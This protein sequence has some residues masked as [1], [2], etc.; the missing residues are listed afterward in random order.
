MS[1]INQRT[2]IAF[3]TGFCLMAYELAAARLLAPTVG[4]STY[5]WTSVIGVIIA[6]L[7]FGF[8][9]GGKIADAR[10]K[11]TDLAWLLLFIAAAILWTLCFNQAILSWVEGFAVDLR[12]QAVVVA[13]ILFAPASFLFGLISPYLAKLQVQ[14]LTQTGQA[15]ATL[16]ASNSLG[17]ITGTFATGFVLFSYTG[18]RQTLAI[19][20]VLILMMSWIITPRDGLM[21]RL[22]VSIGLVLAVITCLIMPPP[23]VTV[24]TATASYKIVDSQS[25]SGR[26]IRN[27]KT[28]PGGSQSGIYLDG[29]KQLPFWYTNEM[30]RLAIKFQPKSVLILG[31]GALT[32]PEYLAKQLPATTI[33][34]VELDP[35]LEKIAYHYFDYKAYP[36]VSLRFADARTFVNKPGAKYDLILVDVYSDS[37]VPASLMTREYGDKII[38][39]L[40]DKGQ[41]VVNLIAGFKPAACRDLFG[42]MDAVYRNNLPHAKYSTNSANKL[43]RAN[44]V[45]VYSRQSILDNS[46]T[47]L[48]NLGGKLYSDNFIP[49]ERLYE[50]CR[51]D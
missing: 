33:D 28:G 17:G 46:M 11:K 24:D 31:G 26:T 15:V 1:Y 45:V 30:A 29:S 7:S 37:Q 18:V 5:V 40:A 16:D 3:T 22:I 39:H 19:L 50:N 6:S 27:L 44:Y 51:R 41:V 14:T 21:R 34:V 12:L 2:I 49:N 10:H 48:D 36:N 47:K 25:Q 23:Y 43:G 9:Q 38:D 32:L 8:W 35:E 4:S 20:A 13:V 42:A